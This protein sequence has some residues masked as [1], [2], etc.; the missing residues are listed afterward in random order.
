MKLTLRQKEYAAGAVLAGG[1]LLLMLLSGGHLPV[2]L[3]GFAAAL[4]ALWLHFIWWRCPACGRHMGRT[5]G[6]CCP[7]CG[8]KI[9]WDTKS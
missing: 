3:A 6:A 1:E 2:L 7:W 9:D 5:K 8:E 4:A